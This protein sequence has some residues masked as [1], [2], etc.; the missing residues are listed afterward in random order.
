[1]SRW[2]MAAAC[3]AIAAPGEAQ[4]IDQRE[5]DA[6][7]ARASGR[8]MEADAMLRVLAFNAQ[9]KPKPGS[10]YD[11]WAELQGVLTNTP[12]PAVAPPGVSLS[13]VDKDDPGVA[14][15]ATATPRDAIATIV[16]RAK[17][18]RIVIL[19]EDHA[20]PRDR[21]FALE[22]ARALRPL[23]YDLLGA[24]TFSHHSDPNRAK[25]DRARMV[26]DGFVRRTAGY[27]TGDPVFA[28]FVRQSLALGY[29][30]FAYETTRHDRAGSPAERIAQREQDQA[31]TIVRMLTVNPGSK[32][33][34]Y[35]GFHHAMETPVPDGDGGQTRWMASRVKAM[36]G[37]DPLTIEQTMLN[38]SGS[39]NLA[40]HALTRSKVKN[41]PIVL[42]D[43]AAPLVLDEYRGANDLQVVHPPLRLIDGRPD[44]MRVMGRAATPVPTEYL[45]T[46]GR[47]LI[48][49]YIASEGEDTIPVDQVLVTVGQA[50]PKLYLP[51]VPV[52]YAVQDP[53]ATP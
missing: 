27:Y 3:F 16:E 31:D 38:D 17:V 35:V 11:R 5:L 49:A 53:P 18:T 2:M 41:R 48:Q 37:I 33:F 42:F 1:M 21:A 36:T 15:I 46:K 23:G 6:M 8:L 12:A 9:G 45:P 39:G 24:E 10:A 13:F 32:L 47:R 7:N 30:P 25:A 19:N 20:S 28:D 29:R 40:L 51:N 14:R 44:W 43:G 26:R 34:L 52:R 22:V 4:Q 50:P